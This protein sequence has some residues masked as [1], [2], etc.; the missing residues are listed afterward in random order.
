MVPI[1]SLDKIWT[2][3]TYVRNAERLVQAVHFD[4]RRNQADKI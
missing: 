1:M 4:L 2:K 3:R